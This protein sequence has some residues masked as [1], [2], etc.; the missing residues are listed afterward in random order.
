MRDDSFKASCYFASRENCYVI[1]MMRQRHEDAPRVVGPQ[2]GNERYILCDST[3][4]T[5]VGFLCLYSSWVVADLLLS[6]SGKC[7]RFF[8]SYHNLKTESY[9]IFATTY[10]AKAVTYLG[11]IPLI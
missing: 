10:P 8:A 7:P 9:V 5:G 4:V 11:T 2:S 6:I 1:F 3:D